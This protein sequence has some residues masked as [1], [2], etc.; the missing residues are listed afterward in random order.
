MLYQGEETFHPLLTLSDGFL[1]N[2]LRYVGEGH[3]LPT[4]LVCQRLAYVQQRRARNAAR[5][6]LPEGAPLPVIL[7]HTSML[8]VVSTV[9]LCEWARDAG[10]PW[11]ASVCAFAASTGKLEVLQWARQNGCPWDWRTYEW[12]SEHAHIQQWADENGCPWKIVFPNGTTSGQVVRLSTV[13]TQLVL[14]WNEITTI[15]PE[16]AQMTNLTELD[17]SG[18]KIT[19]IPREI[20]Q[21]TN[22][23][24]LN[25]GGNKIT[26]IPPEIA[27]LTN[28]RK[29]LLRWN[30]ISILP[31]EIAQLTNLTVLDLTENKITI[32]PPEIAQLTNLTGLNLLR[33]PVRDVPAVIHQSLP[34]LRIY[35]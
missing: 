27:Q 13:G 8:T 32:F 1:Q 25:L 22:L 29:L 33:N 18:N 23:R 3:A 34:N 24:V 28:L 35:I 11:N 19:I 31:P 17:L 21:L 16:I 12:A 15:P 9:E 7:Y 5:A 4:A 30:E 2:M 14:R 20:A 26:I 10:C 6:M